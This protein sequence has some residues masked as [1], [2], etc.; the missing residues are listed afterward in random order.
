MQL[1]CSWRQKG[2]EN[3]KLLGISAGRLRGWFFADFLYSWRFIMYWMIKQKNFFLTSKPSKPM[4]F[5]LTSK[6]A[7]LKI[8]LGAFPLRI[9][10]AL[11]QLCC[12]LCLISF[13]FGFLFYLHVI[14]DSWTCL[15]FIYLPSSMWVIPFYMYQVG[16]VQMLA[17]SRPCILS[18]L[19]WTVSSVKYLLYLRKWGWWLFAAQ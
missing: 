14:A 19:G 3:V 15:L 1:T 7:F 18:S 4:F 13:R 9:I 11:W 12:L 16:H 17:E 8:Q 2:S 10:K 6:L 5:K